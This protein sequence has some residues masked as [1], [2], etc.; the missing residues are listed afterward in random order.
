MKILKRLR[1]HLRN[2]Q[3]VHVRQNEVGNLTALVALIDRFID[4]RPEYA[5]EWDDF[6]SWKNSN[7]NI[8]NIRT[9]IAALEPLF[10]S[11]DRSNRTKA[12]EELL[13]ERNQAA[14][15][16]GIDSRTEH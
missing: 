9:R 4:N 15:L 8:E 10:F 7:P 16:A 5:L 1:D 13:R 3:R 6:V 14:A 12:L 2:S 11:K